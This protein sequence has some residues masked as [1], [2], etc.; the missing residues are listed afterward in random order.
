MYYST[1]PNYIHRE[2][3]SVRC[4][5]SLILRLKVRYITFVSPIYIHNQN[6]LSESNLELNI[7]LWYVSLAGIHQ[8]Q[9]GSS[10]V[11]LL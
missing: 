11:Q 7:N 2:Q 8:K 1:G 5:K 6:H 10:Y 4:E 3:D 9:K